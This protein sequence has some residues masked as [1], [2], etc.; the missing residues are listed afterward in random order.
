[1]NCNDIPDAHHSY[2]LDCV[3]GSSGAMEENPEDPNKECSYPSDY[4][5]CPGC[6]YACV[7]LDEDCPEL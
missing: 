3:C 4:A 7:H 5:S 2:V 1:M 6:V